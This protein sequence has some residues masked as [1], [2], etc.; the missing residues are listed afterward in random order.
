MFIYLSLNSRAEKGSQKSR[1]LDRTLDNRVFQGS[2][3]K[4][5][6]RGP[7]TAVVQAVHIPRSFHDTRPPTSPFI[8]LCASKL[9]V[10]LSDCL[11]VGKREMQNFRVGKDL[12]TDR[13]HINIYVASFCYVPGMTLD[14]AEANR[15]K[16]LP[17]PKCS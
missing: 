9:S 1:G 14:V 12:L 7:V 15:S 3:I 10:T 6:A 5:V 16:S 2:G 17:C 11:S 8:I 4:R 13:H